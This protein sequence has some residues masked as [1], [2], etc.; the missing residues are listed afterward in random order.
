MYRYAL[1]PASRARGNLIDFFNTTINILVK[2]IWAGIAA[3]ALSW[4]TWLG[5]PQWG[6]W[7]YLSIA[8]CGLMPEK[9]VRRSLRRSDHD[10]ER[11]R[12]GG[13][14]PATPTGGR[15]LQY[16]FS[17]PLAL[18]TDHTNSVRQEVVECCCCLWTLPVCYRHNHTNPTPGTSSSVTCKHS[19]FCCLVT[20]LFR[21]ANVTASVKSTAICFGRS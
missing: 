14:D 18:Q 16:G 9:W 6:C 21:N 8:R 5:P 17:S 3:R 15:R 1:W 13:P 20:S 11:W 12:W 10:P 2:M 19:T 4:Y 7:P